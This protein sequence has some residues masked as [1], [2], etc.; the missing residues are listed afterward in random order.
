MSKLNESKSNTILKTNE[1]NNF[2]TNN[3]TSTSKN[4]KIFLN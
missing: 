1:I 2:E 4:L 3:N